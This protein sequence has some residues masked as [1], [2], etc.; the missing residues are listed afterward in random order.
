MAGFYLKQSGGVA[1]IASLAR[2]G[3]EMSFVGN[4]E[5]FDY[6]DFMI[7]PGSEGDF[8]SALMGWLGQEDNPGPGTTLADREL[9]Y[10]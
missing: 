3:D 9:P 2:Q 10:P 4:T 5:T 6:N 8:F 1:A 7:R